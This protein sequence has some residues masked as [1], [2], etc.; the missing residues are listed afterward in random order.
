MQ[1]VSNVRIKTFQNKS[2][3]VKSNSM[4]EKSMLMEPY[5]CS[6]IDL[7]HGKPSTSQF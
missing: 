6:K 4:A 3:C 7:I 5:R 1:V 2:G